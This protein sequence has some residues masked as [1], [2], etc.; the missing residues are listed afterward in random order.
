MSTENLK[1]QSF[2]Q[3]RRQ[4]I[5]CE[6]E[7]GVK[8]SEKE[9]EKQTGIGRTPIREALIQLRNEK[10]VYTIPQSGTYVS[11]VDMCSAANALFARETIEKEV[12]QECGVKLTAM[13][14]KQLEIILAELNRALQMGNMKK[15][16]EMD[17]AFYKTCYEIAGRAEI[18]HWLDASNTHFERYR[19]LRL[20]VPKLKWRKITED[21]DDLFNALTSRNLSEVSFLTTMHLHL[22][23]EEKSLV[24]QKFSDY[25]TADSFFD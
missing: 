4:I 24:L 9:L 19:W 2:Q 23:I 25:F 17:N 13:G 12:M 20:Q 11:L 8:I 16:F 15:Y 21:Y 5:F 1:S 7:P 14:E 6:L 22:T 3:I 18:W 10:L